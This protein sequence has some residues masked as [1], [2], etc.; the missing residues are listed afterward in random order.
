MN[1]FP[2][3]DDFKQEDTKLRLHFL[4]GVFN[5]LGEVVKKPTDHFGNQ[6]FADELLIPMQGAFKEMPQHFD[7]LYEAVAKLEDAPR[8]DD[9]IN[10]HGLGGM[11]L[12]FKLAVVARAEKTYRDVGGFF[13][14]RRL[15]GALEPFLDSLMA[16][17][18]VGGAIR[19]F[20]DGVGNVG[21]DD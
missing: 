13:K 7:S 2:V 20:K 15:L 17:V 4:T 19:E 1:L 9:P 6:L 16:A 8:E 5:L 14:L 21:P 11:Q 12:R 18:G 10:E 3:Q